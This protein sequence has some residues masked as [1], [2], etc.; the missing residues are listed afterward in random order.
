MTQGWES[1][2]DRSRIRNIVTNAGWLGAERIVR[3][4]TSFMVVV[5]IA[6]SLGPE[7]FGT[8]NFAQSIVI[9]L[10]PLVTMGLNP[11]LVRDLVQHPEQRDSLLSSAVLLRLLGALVFL[12]AAQMLGYW[13]TD[14]DSQVMWLVGIIGLGV[15]AYLADGID[16]DYQ[17][18][19]QNKAVVYIKLV[20][21]AVCTILKIILIYV[22]ASVI[23][24]AIVMTLENLLI[25]GLLW[26]SAKRAQYTFAWR[27]SMAQ[28]HYLLTEA[29]PLFLVALL[30]TLFGRVDQLLLGAM[31][32]Y[33]TLG[34]Y[35][36][37]WKVV[38]ALGM[39]AY[40]A[41]TALAPALS[42]LQRES[43]VLF[44]SRYMLATR[45]LFWG[46]I[47][48]CSVLGVFL[49]DFLLWA[50]GVQYVDAIGPMKILIWSLPMVVLG[51]MT[52]QWSLHM[53][54]MRF[55]IG[56]GAF[57]LLMGALL[58]WSMIDTWGQLGA[59]SGILLAQLLAN[60]V[61]PVLWPMGRQLLRIQLKSLLIWQR[62]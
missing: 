16:S 29:A 59:A 28:V 11:V 30:A 49:P 62:G 51:H 17:A 60:L 23:W 55:M 19:M 4:A 3:A 27:P 36:V 40:F 53:D 46:S 48:A 41:V 21:F 50:F 56:Q 20:C 47:L 25:A 14:N 44:E 8:L 39:F 52:F 6:R 45:I 1:L 22:A 34:H 42:A 38:E 10:T 31:A 37:A 35:A 12:V 2:R 18:R 15:F 33:E 43:Q 24:F 26:A 5:W 13:L 7:L 54:G 61:Y 57:M 9:G 58:C 32:G